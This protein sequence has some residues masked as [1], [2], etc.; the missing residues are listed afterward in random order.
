MTI[1]ILNYIYLLD[2]VM[3]VV[4]EDNLVKVEEI[5]FRCSQIYLRCDKWLLINHFVFQTVIT[6]NLK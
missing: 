3:L 1:D 4:E 5:E 6:I 2:S